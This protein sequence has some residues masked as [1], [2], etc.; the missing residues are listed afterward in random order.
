MYSNAKHVLILSLY[1]CTPLQCTDV[2]RLP[3]I[4]KRTFGLFQMDA[5]CFLFPALKFIGSVSVFHEKTPPSL[6]CISMP[7]SMHI[8]MLL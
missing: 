7:G 1:D 6:R 5:L 3:P 8:V 4:R 2:L